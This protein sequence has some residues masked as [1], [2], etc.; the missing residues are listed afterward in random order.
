MTFLSTP[1]AVLE[2]VTVPITVGPAPREPLGALSLGFAL[3][4]AL[5]RQFKAVT[6]SEVAFALG[7][8]CGPRHSPSATP[9]RSP[10]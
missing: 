10:A 8:A 4:D 2:V 1:R 3:D 9:R 6:D 5:A 7:G